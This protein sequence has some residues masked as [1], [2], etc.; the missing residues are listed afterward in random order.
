MVQA[1][2]RPLAQ[3]NI[4]FPARRS[5][6]NLNCA[7]NSEVSDVFSLTYPSKGFNGYEFVIENIRQQIHLA[8]HSLI[9]RLGL[10][11]GAVVLGW[12]RSGAVAEGKRVF[13]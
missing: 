8:G 12:V 5:L 11:D 10:S 7:F 6:A 2:G 9:T 4:S 3:P 13:Y 1:Y